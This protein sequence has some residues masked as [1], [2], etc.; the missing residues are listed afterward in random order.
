MVSAR[1]PR[2]ARQ[3][4]AEFYVWSD[5]PQKYKDVPIIFN[6]VEPSNWTLD[7]VAGSHYW[8]R[9][10]SHQPDL[11]FEN[12]EV[13]DAISKS[14]ISGSILAWTAC[15]WTRC[16]IFNERDGTTC[17]SLPETHTF[18]KS[19]RAHVD[20]NYGDRMLL[21]EANLWPEDAVSYFGEGRGDECHM[22]FSFSIDAAPVHGLAH[23]RP[24]A[25]HGHL[26]ADPGHP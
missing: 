19:L 21:A 18:L 7:P 14:L 5:D 25:D 12:A 9:F 22:A 16:R 26:G 20:A 11:N 15:G 24:P 8:H 17:E 3:P 1:P 4:L 23:G 10:F 2:K 13:R 6:G